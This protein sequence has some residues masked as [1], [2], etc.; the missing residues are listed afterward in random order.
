L[1]AKH[2]EVVYEEAIRALD[3]QR[4]AFDALRTRTGILL[5]A[6]AVATS[7]LGGRE[8]AQDQEGVWSWLAVGLFLAF[9]AASLK[10]LWPRA[11]GSEGFTAVPSLVIEEYLEIDEPVELSTLYRDLAL[12][13]EEAHD[14]NKVRHLFELTRYFRAAVIL[15]T[16]E[17]TAWVVALA[18][19]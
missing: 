12:H 7:F 2:Y 9:G 15:L 19:G 1:S 18:T 6:G 16:L 3:I 4:A 5:S 17:V 8:F 10:V 11:E 13:A 14:I